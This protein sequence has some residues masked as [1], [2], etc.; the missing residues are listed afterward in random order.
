MEKEYKWDEELYRKIENKVNE[1]M[2]DFEGKD[3]FKITDKKF[4]SIGAERVPT[5]EM[6]K[7]KLA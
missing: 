4:V 5:V 6:I 7:V 1:N 3:I 2:P